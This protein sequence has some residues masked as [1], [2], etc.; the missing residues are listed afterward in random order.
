[1]ALYKAKKA[2]QTLAAQKKLEEVG[3]KFFS[4]CFVKFF[5]K[6]SNASEAQFRKFWWK[7]RKLELGAN[8]LFKQALAK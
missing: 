5:W 6:K 7:T 1:M 4:V 2:G 3:D 8:W